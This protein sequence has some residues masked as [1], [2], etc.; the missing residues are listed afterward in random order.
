M[1]TVTFV[2]LEEGFLITS[3]RDEKKNRA[4]IAPKIYAVADSKLMFPKDKKAGGTWIVAKN[5]G[6][7]IVL[8]NGAFEKHQVKEKYSKSRGIILFEVIQNQ[9]PIA[10]F[11]TINLDGVEPFTLIVFQNN[12]LIELKWDENQ[13]HVIEHSCKEQHIWSSSTLYSKEQRNLRQKWFNDFKNINMPLSEEKILSFHN[14]TQPQ[15]SEFGLVINRENNI[16]TVSITQVKLQNNVVQM[17]YLDMESN[18]VSE[19]LSF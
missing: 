5:D 6:T 1:C 3:N 19:I 11:S 18:I 2:P 10:Y 13:K 14:N 17:K 8:L 16:K 4:T 12:Q 7:C 9:N 15:N